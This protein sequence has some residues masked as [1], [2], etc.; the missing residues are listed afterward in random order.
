[1]PFEWR[2]QV[3]LGLALGLRSRRR[4]DENHFHRCTSVLPEQTR[5]AV[6]HVIGLCDEL[7]RRIRRI[8]QSGGHVLWQETVA[9]RMWDLQIWE[10]AY[11][12]AMR[13]GRPSDTDRVR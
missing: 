6:E 2:P 5:T 11:Q 12:E 1:M 8:H 7:E 9:R 10:P 13:Q 3:H 4:L